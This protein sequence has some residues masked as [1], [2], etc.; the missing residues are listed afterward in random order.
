MLEVPRLRCRP[1]CWPRTAFAVRVLGR[2]R[3]RRLI[4]G[5]RRGRERVG[6]RKREEEVPREDR[7]DH[8]EEGRRGRIRSKGRRWDP[9]CWRER[10]GGGLRSE[11]SWKEGQEERQG[12]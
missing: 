2:G 3:E 4:R 6:R 10:R 7:E 5:E 11:E 8:R 12:S 9:R 1:P